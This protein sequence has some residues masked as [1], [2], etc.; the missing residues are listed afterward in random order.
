M[1]S[2]PTQRRSRQRQLLLTIDTERGERHASCLELR[3]DLV[4]VIAVSHVAAVLSVETNVI[5]LL[6]F[7]FLFFSVWWVWVG[8]TLYADRFESDEHEYRSLTF[9]GMLSVAALALRIE[10]AFAPEGSDAFAVFYS[11]VNLVIAAN[12]A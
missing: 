10:S 4:F 11:I 12:Y 3:F 1:A 5:G 7:A 2:E 9:A 6:K 8:H